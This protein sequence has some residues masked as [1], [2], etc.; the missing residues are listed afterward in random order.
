MPTQWL[1]VHYPTRRKVY[2]DDQAAGLTNK[3]FAVGEGHHKIDLG[4]RRNYTPAKYEREVTGTTV[5]TPLELR[6]RPKV[7]S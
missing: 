4:P 5:E 6:F 7:D 1:K 3:T 2:V